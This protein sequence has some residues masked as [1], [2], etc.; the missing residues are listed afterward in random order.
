MFNVWSYFDGWQLM[1]IELGCVSSMV[2]VACGGRGEIDIVSFRLKLSAKWRHAWLMCAECNMCEYCKERWLFDSSSQLEQWLR[3]IV[4]ASDCVR[5]WYDLLKPPTH[6]ILVARH[7]FT[8]KSVSGTTNWSSRGYDFFKPPT[9][10]I[11]DHFIQ[12]SW[13]GQQIDD[14]ADMISSSRQLFEF[15]LRV[16]I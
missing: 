4:L 7:H 10:W 12:K 9:H 8:Q 2:V 16:I 14:L 11:L 6:W 3:N 15:L 1:M 13:T 5:I